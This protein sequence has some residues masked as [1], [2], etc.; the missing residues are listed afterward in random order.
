MATTKQRERI[1]R[2]LRIY[3]HSALPN[4]R[5]KMANH[6]GSSIGKLLFFIIVALSLAGCAAA[7]P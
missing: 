1:G 7:A 5:G 6:Y 3:L 4:R 2:K